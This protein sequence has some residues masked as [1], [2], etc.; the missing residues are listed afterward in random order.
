MSLHPD[1]YDAVCRAQ[2]RGT[3]AWAERDRLVQQSQRGRGG[4]MALTP[5][6]IVNSTL[7]RLRHRLR[8]LAPPLAVGRSS[9]FRRREPP[10]P[11]V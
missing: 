9:T 8:E 5:S 3:L 2:Q 11:V 1:I 10:R 4:R 6:P 7:T